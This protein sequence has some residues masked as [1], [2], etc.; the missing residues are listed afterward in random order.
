MKVPHALRACFAVA[1]T[2]FAATA[3]HAGAVS[4]YVIN[5]SANG[6]VTDSG[7]VQG[8]VSQRNLFR[9]SLDAAQMQVENFDAQT[10]GNIS[11]GSSLSILGGAASL[12]ATDPNNFG[13]VARVRDDPY[14]GGQAFLGRFNTTGDP[15]TLP[16]GGGGGRWWETSYEVTTFS[17]AN[18]VSGF[19]VFLT[20]LGDFDGALN[21][22]IFDAAGTELFQS[23]LVS[24]GSGVSTNNGALA[25]FGYTNSDKAFS[26]VV[27]T[28]AQRGCP[29]V[30]GAAPTCRPDFFDLVGFDDVI[31]GPLRG[32]GGG[33]PVPEPGSLALAGLALAGLGL[34][35]RKT[36]A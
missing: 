31:T 3:V 5:P 10:L 23:D 17:F 25:F 2:S 22:S 13:G 33:T 29:D 6:S 14:A 28:I 24:T 21:V 36:R 1:I 35:R 4:Y 7:A 26:K 32:N 9:A 19:G 8:P 12:T 20:D 16:S 34:S 11:L 15:Q 30:A 27:F 18:A